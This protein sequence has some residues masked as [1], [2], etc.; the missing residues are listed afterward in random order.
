MERR[1]TPNTEA[2]PEPQ[3][4]RPSALHRFEITAT[5]LLTLAT[6][7][8]AWSGY[9]AT[10]WGAETTEATA[11]ANAARFAATRASDL[12]N[13]QTEIDVATFMQWVDAYALNETMLADFYYA[14]FREEFEPAVKAWVATKPLQN[15]DAPLT[16]FAMPEYKLAAREEAERQDAITTER[17]DDL[18]RNIERQSNYVFAVVLFATALF[19]AGTSTRVSA[20]SLRL[21]ILG[22]GLVL[23]VGTIGWIATFP[24]SLSL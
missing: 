17:S 18:R 14:R 5:V 20:R 3:K 7:A 15:P 13:A 22:V 21:A 24:V 9:Q 12:A 4:P 10:R 11:A 16:P 19:F 23:F 2:G 1:L 8:T 6:V